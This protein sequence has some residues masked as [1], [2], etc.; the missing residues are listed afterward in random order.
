MKID[1]ENSWVGHCRS[2]QHQSDERDAS[3]AGVRLMATGACSSHVNGPRTAEARSLKDSTVS[4]K[5]FPVNE[6]DI[7]ITKKIDI[8]HR[9]DVKT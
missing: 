6:N 8:V 3:P 2:G 7:S 4:D 9:T 1:K 5:C